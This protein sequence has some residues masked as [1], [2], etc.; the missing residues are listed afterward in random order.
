MIYS[1][2]GHTDIEVSKICLGTMTFG[3]QNTENEAHEQLDFA[4]ENGVN[5]IDTAEMYPVPP[6]QKTQ[7]LTEK[8]IGSWLNKTKKR[9]KVIIAS[10]V[11]GPAP[12]FDYI[13][14]PLKID[15]KNIEAA[16]EENLKRLNTDY[17]DL[18]QIHWPQRETNY[19]GELNYKY[20]KENK[21]EI[22]DNINESYE[23][24]NSLVTQGKIRTIGLSNDT[25]WGTMKFIEISNAKSFSKIVSVQNPYSLLNRLYEINM[26][27]IAE[28]ENVKLLA[29]SPLGFGVL[30]GKYLD[31]SPKNARLTIW[32]RFNRYSNKFCKEATIK[33][34]N[35]AKKYGL[36]PTQLA[37]AFVNNQPFVAS[38]IIGAT[39]LSQL[40]EN[41]QSINITL[42]EEIKNEIDAINMSHPNPAP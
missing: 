15:K 29:Y 10:K 22:F 4:L 8:Y 3:E 13:R 27:E 25:S 35:L 34:V 31:N 7:G 26:A 20:T 38:N 17:I 11:T 24:L 33:Y 1:K 18:Y 42:D 5:F 28:I 36:T 40:E 30:T 19:F 9:D 14:N 39:N 37:L 2:L 23:T 21:N 12:D 41:I 32:N 16:I 6:K